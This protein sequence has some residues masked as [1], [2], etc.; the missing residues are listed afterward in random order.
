MILKLELLLAEWGSVGMI[1]TVQQTRRRNSQTNIY[2]D[3]RGPGP[4][5]FE[6]DLRIMGLVGFATNMSPQ[7]FLDDPRDPYGYT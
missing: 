4:V 1:K 3:P 2:E 5:E 7:A 6:E